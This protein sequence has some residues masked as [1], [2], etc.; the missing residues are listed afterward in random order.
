ML[1]VLNSPWVLVALFIFISYTTEAM[2]GFGSIVIALSLGVMVLPLEQLLPV[3]VPLNLLLSGYLTTRY[4]RL[5]DWRL[6]LS[7]ILPLMVLGTALGFVSRPWIDQDLLQSL[8][9]VLI[10]AF[11][12]RQLWRLRDIA[13]VIEQRPLVARVWMLL[14]GVS[15]GLFASGGPLLALA[16]DGVKLDKSRF[17]ATLIIVWLTL[18][19]LLTLGYAVDGVLATHFPVMAALVPVVLAGIVL[20]DWLHHRVNE[21]HFR[22]FLFSLLLLAGITILLRGG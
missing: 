10:V 20:G 4:Y 17:R 15:H 11:S 12:V 1:E 13:K 22:V 18:N 9:G 3:V 2:T 16:L 19:G 7:R 21:H 5:V 8:F 6:L 14:A